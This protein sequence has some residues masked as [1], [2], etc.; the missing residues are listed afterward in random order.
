VA[1]VL[2]LSAN[3]GL[4]TVAEG[5]ET[6]RQ[7]DRLR[8]LGCQQAQGYLFARPAAVAEPD[9]TYCVIGSNYRH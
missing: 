8:E 5:I 1:A 3:L 7:L 9:R 6:P 2:D 4:R